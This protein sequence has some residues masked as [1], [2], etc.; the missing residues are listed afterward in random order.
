MEL[1]NEKERRILGSLFKM[2][3]SAVSEISKDTL[4]NRTALYHTIDSLTRKGL[5]TCVEKNKISYYEAIPIDQYEKWAEKKLASF[6]ESVASD[7][8]TFSS[9]KKDRSESIYADVKYFEGFEAVKNLYA[10]TIYNNK[11]KQLYSITDYEKGYATLGRWV[12]DEYLPERVKRGIWV[13]NLVPDSEFGRKYIESADKLL[14]DICL[15]DMFKN[16]GIEVNLYDEKI[17]IV[18]F[19][20]DHPVGIIIQNRIITKAFREIFNYI[21][22]TGKLAKNIRKK[23]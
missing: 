7:I 13:K 1:L 23:P 15:V 3:K 12:H 14:R 5:V 6:K 18:S 16:L 8:K 22:K 11:E 19:D 10:D 2:G 21:W 17:A 9:I 4:L 20:E